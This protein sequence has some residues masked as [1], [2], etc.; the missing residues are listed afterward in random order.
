[1]NAA[2]GLASEVE[3]ALR[4]A[5]KYTDAAGGKLSA[6]VSGA[7]RKHQSASSYKQKC[8]GCG[9]F[10]HVY[11][12]CIYRLSL[13]SPQWVSDITRSVGDGTSRSTTWI[14]SCT[15]TIAERVCSE[16]GFA[17]RS[18]LRCRVNPLV[19]SGRYLGV[20]S[21]LRT[22]AAIP[23]PGQTCSRISRLTN[24]IAALVSRTRSPAE[25]R[26][27]IG[28]SSHDHGHDY[29]KDSDRNKDRERDRHSGTVRDTRSSGRDPTPDRRSHSREKVDDHKKRTGNARDKKGL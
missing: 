26:S 1:M 9:S 2:E 14:L 25:R 24:A 21:P 16:S 5:C 4:K 6:P 10:D 29:A 20:G 17:G 11:Q 13:L 22:V 12:E 28:E 23:R 15:R 18:L 27:M 8:P 7:K 19:E 3:A